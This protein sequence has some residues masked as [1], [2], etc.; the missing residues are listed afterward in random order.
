M[1]RLHLLLMPL[2][3]LI[4]FVWGVLYVIAL[5]PVILV[6]GRTPA[7]VRS[8]VLRL[9]EKQ[10]RYQERLGVGLPHRLEV[11]G[12]RRMRRAHKPADEP[13]TDDSQRLPP[14]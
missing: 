5:I 2:Y 12:V 4:A 10:L 8:N 6:T 7:R 11:L 3:I 13:S 1:G 14:E 9:R